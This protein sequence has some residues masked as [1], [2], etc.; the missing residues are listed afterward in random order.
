MHM[1][2]QGL[3]CQISASS[4]ENVSTTLT[5]KLWYLPGNGRLT[6]CISASN[7]RTLAFSTCMLYL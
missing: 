2:A 5:N 7:R 6:L 3:G 4:R 1:E